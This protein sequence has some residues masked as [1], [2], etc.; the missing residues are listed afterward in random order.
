MTPT[1]QKAS[2]QAIVE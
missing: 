1:V 2:T